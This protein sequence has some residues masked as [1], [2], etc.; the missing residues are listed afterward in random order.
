MLTILTNQL[1]TYTIILLAILTNQ[2]ITIC[3]L[4]PKRHISQKGDMIANHP[5][6]PSPTQLMSAGHRCATIA[7]NHS[8]TIKENFDQTII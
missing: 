3:L 6:I 8:T 2:L 4:Y 5:L 1:I 7:L